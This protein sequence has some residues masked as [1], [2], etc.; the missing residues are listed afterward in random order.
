MI[1]IILEASHEMLFIL[2]KTLKPGHYQLVQNILVRD[3][4]PTLHCKHILWSSTCSSSL[5]IESQRLIP[6]LLQTYMIQYYSLNLQ[7]V[8]DLHDFS[9]LLRSASDVSTSISRHFF[10]HGPI[11]YWISYTGTVQTALLVPWTYCSRLYLW[12]K[13]LFSPALGLSVISRRDLRLLDFKPGW[14]ILPG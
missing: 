14:L 4:I 10:R 1:P 9:F 6:T 2:P 13:N 5:R 11:R 12:Q 8:T 7:P 3:F